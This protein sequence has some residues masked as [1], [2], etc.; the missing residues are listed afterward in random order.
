[1]SP[2]ATA[3]DDFVTAFAYLFKDNPDAGVCKLN[4]VRYINHG[5]RQFKYDF[6]IVD[7]D[8]RQVVSQLRAAG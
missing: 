6:I 2:L 1:M 4:G 8:P 7:A 3:V 5:T